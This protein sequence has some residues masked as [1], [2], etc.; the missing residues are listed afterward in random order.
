MKIQ[1]VAIAAAIL[2]GGSIVSMRQVAAEEKT[3]A[4]NPA[5][6]THDFLVANQGKRV[7]VRIG[8][9]DPIEGVVTKVGDH[10]VHLSGLGAGRDYY[11]A[12][13]SIDRIDAVIFKAR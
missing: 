10:Q 12:L 1:V 13:V 5:L 9:G 3:A 11:D 6:T 8:N 7:S 4:V 2:V